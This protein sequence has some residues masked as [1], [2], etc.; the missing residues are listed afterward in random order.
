MM[1]EKKFSDTYRALAEFTI[2][3][4]KHTKSNGIVLGR[5]YAP[6]QFQVIGMGA[7][8]PTGLTQCVNYRL[9]KRKKTCFE[10]SR[11]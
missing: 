7:G 9:P 10:S 8:Q 5:E 4:C 1:T 3:A 6:G 2:V 11:S